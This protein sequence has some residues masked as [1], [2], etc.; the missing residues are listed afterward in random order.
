MQ[1]ERLGLITSDALPQFIKEGG[2][3]TIGPVEREGRLF[4]RCIAHKPDGEALRV[5]VSRGLSDKYFKSLDSAYNFFVKI[6]PEAESFT[7][8]THVE[9]IEDP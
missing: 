5:L 9:K 2:R 1:F 6:H 4:W 7:V 8:S 3:V